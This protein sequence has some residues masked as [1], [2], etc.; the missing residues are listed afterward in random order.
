MKVLMSV[1]IIVALGVV[2]LATASDATAK[3]ETSSLPRVMQDSSS[4]P[5]TPAPSPSPA[6]E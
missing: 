1:F 6:V 4:P 3:R 5:C 2:A